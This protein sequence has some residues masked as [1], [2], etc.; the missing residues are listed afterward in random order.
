M[1]L[2]RAGT[3]AGLILGTAAYMSPEP[4]RG[5]PPDRRADVW[6]FGVVLFARPLRDGRW[7]SNVRVGRDGKKVAFLDHASRGDN[8]AAVK[9]VGP[10]GVA[11]TVSP[12]ASNGL[13]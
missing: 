13:A 9:I 3:A 7:V 10:D 8:Q 1:T 6:A 2:A 4:A 12:S 5:K 11:R